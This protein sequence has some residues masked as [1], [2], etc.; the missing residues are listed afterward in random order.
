MVIFYIILLCLLPVA[1]LRGGIPLAL[2]KGYDPIFA[3]IFCVI[4]NILDIPI[5]FYFM[6]RIHNIL[7]KNKT[8]KS[9]FEWR[10]NTVRKKIEK[11]VERYGYLGLALF[12]AIPLPG[13]GAYTGVIA[14][15][16]LNLKRKNSYLAIALGVAIAGVIVTITY[17][18]FR[19]T[20]HFFFKVF[21]I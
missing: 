15:W 13:T 9:F 18:F 7:M 14:A 6:D 5:M 12:V 2:S 17:L 10:I 4:I 21:K 11:S 3:F 19:E 16:I 20:F 8:Y 1:E